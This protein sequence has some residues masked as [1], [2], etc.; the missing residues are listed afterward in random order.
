MGG[1][2][3]EREIKTAVNIFDII[4]TIRD[5]QGMTLTEL[6]ENVDLARSTLH[7]YLQTLTD[8]EYLVRDD[9]QYYVSLKFLN[10]GNYAK[11]NRTA[12]RQV[13]P[14][15]EEIG[16][17]TG[18]NVWFVVK[19]NGSAVYVDN[20]SGSRVL[21]RFNTAGT[22][23]YLHCMAAGKAILAH[24]P[25]EQ[26]NAIIKERGL[27]AFTE[28]TITDREV[29]FKELE[30]IRE[31]GIAYSDGERSEEIRAVA[32]PVMNGDQVIGAIT[33]GAPTKRLTGE[34]FEEELPKLVSGAANRIEFS[35][36]QSESV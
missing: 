23:E 26:V 9:K 33:L 14:A 24:L 4:E 25:E 27:P 11:N 15:L 28:N 16:D 5:N 12:W 6:S 21:Y 20:Y 19:E 7:S 31:E 8:M 17:E 1:N 36:R 18:E 22:R 3:P 29:L 30:R 10:L 2:T 35:F 34:F 13:R 32:S